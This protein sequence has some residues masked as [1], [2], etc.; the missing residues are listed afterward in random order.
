MS[1]PV[2]IIGIGAVVSSVVLTAVFVAA[3][4]WVM[5]K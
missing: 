2:R 4:V 1:N 5:M 3:V